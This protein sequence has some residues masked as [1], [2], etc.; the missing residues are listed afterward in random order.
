MGRPATGF[1]KQIAAV[2]TVLGDHQDAC[3]MEDWLRQVGPKTRSTREAMLIGQLIGLQRAEA[4]ANRA[5]WPEVWA[6]A[7]DP[8]LRGWLG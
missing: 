5:A 2:Q 6:R 4:A 8:A 3:V 7:S 1:A